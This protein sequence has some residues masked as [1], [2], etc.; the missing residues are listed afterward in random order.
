MYLIEI[1]EGFAQQIS[2]EE[3]V[4]K[5]QLITLQI[6]RQTVRLCARGVDGRDF[7]WLKF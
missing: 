3:C 5:F 6:R 4:T 2:K 7:S 1:C